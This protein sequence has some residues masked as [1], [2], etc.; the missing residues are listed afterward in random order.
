M[1]LLRVAVH[2]C[3]AESCHHN[4][5]NLNQIQNPMHV[6]ICIENLVG[7]FVE[8]VV[9]IGETSPLYRPGNFIS[10]VHFIQHVHLNV[11]YR[12]KLR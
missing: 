2:T 4:H 5:L 10:E 12:K 3:G 9:Y 8:L 1:L 11:P 6:L 7:A